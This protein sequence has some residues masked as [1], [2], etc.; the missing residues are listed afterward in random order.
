MTVWFRN[1]LSTAIFANHGLTKGWGFKD[2]CHVY[3]LMRW[4]SLAPFGNR[5]HTSEM[6]ATRI[7]IALLCLIRCWESARMAKFLFHN[8]MFLPSWNIARNCAK[9][10]FSAI[11]KILICNIMVN[12]NQMYWQLRNTYVAFVSSCLI[13]TAVWNPVCIYRLHSSIDEN[14]YLIFKLIITQ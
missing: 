2:H 3:H 9:F 10:S 4:N 6:G 11:F 8:G 12:H 7:F 14:Q 13:F 5:T 1:L